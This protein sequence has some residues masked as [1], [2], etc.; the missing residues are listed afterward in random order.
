MARHSQS[1]CRLVYMRARQN[2]SWEESNL[3][4]GEGTHKAVVY[5]LAYTRQENW[6]A[7]VDPGLSHMRRARRGT[8]PL[9]STGLCLEKVAPA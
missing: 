9:K 3:K 7:E 2:C 4:L 8:Q 6:P 1:N 5:P